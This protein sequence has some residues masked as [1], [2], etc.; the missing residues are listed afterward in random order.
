MS[1]SINP[2]GR[3]ISEKV[4][5]GGGMTC[6][7]GGGRSATCSFQ[8]HPAPTHR[9]ASTMLV[10]PDPGPPLL[11]GPQRDP[12]AQDIVRTAWSVTRDDLL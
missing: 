11:R 8:K 12:S 1:P 7:E 4:G 6:L 2:R 10:A 9:V 3:D 5:G